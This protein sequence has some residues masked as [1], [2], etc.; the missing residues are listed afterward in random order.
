MSATVDDMEGVANLWLGQGAAIVSSGEGREIEMHLLQA[1]VGKY[2]AMNQRSEKIIEWLQETRAC[3][4]LVF[5]NSRNSAHALTAALENKLH[6]TQWPVHMHI[7]ILSKRERERVETEMK[8]GHFGICVATSTMEI[9][10]DIGDIDMVVLAEPPGSINAFLQRIG[11]G[12]R[13]SGVC[14][15]LA[16]CS[17]ENEKV[18]YEALLDCN[19]IS[20]K[21][22]GVEALN[23]VPFDPFIRW[24]D[25]IVAPLSMNPV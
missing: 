10:I 1:P 22:Q 5:A 3:K 12:N 17:N 7:G 8:S 6:N 15:V 23:S 14:S 21:L 4:V 18:I 2:D 25:E 16:L 9:G 11:R 19:R 13:R 24:L 20:E